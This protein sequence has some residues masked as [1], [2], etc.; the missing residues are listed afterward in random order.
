MQ[1]T[2]WGQKHGFKTGVLVCD[3]VKSSSILLI[4]TRSRL[5]AR[6]SWVL[7]QLVPDGR[8]LLLKSAVSRMLGLFCYEPTACE[9]R[10]FDAFW[11]AGGVSCSGRCTMDCRGGLWFTEA[12]PAQLPVS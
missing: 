6:V 10:A 1:G 3:P 12:L 4:D 7:G 8:K 11:S 9:D 2:P 5:Q